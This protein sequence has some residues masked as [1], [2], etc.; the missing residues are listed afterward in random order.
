MQKRTT[1]AVTIAAL[2]GG[3][4]VSSVAL[5]GKG[6]DTVIPKTFMTVRGDTQPSG[7]GDTILANCGASSGIQT[8]T[9]E[10]TQ[11]GSGSKVEIEVR[12]ARPDTVYTVWL[13]MSGSGPGDETGTGGGSGGSPMTGGG[14]TP[15]APGSALDG[16]LHYSPPFAGSPT[17]TN[18]FVT[19]AYGNADFQ[20]ELDFPLIGGAYPFQNAST[21]A[22]EALRYA[23]STWP[24]VRKPHP[25]A[26]PTDPN[27]SA[28]F[29]MRVISHCTDQVGHGLSPAVRE[30]WFQYP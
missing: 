24:L 20:I 1:L 26:N 12:N 21:E 11:S 8:A 25:V 5:A 13:R 28:P 2:L 3:L 22:V 4:T 9:V 17:P 23:G 18:G 15:L 27:I 29:L 6:D 10:A 16:L 14:A 30:A 7:S 19:D